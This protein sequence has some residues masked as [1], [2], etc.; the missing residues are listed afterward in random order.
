[1]FRHFESQ[2]RTVREDIRKQIKS[3][4]IQSL[5]REVGNDFN[6]KKYLLKE[7][8]DGCTCTMLRKQE[9]VESLYEE[10]EREE[11]RLELL[12]ILFIDD[13]DYFNTMI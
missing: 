4:T 12:Q 2:K 7:Y 11:S 1:M 8:T 6:F 10:I 13:S 5:S 3:R 9:D